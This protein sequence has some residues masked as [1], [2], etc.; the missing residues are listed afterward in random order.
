L[1]RQ[2]LLSA[3]P[4]YRAK[5]PLQFSQHGAEMFRTA[6]TALNFINQ[7]HTDRR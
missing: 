5:T 7:A 2:T 1:Y 4:H 3:L 6:L